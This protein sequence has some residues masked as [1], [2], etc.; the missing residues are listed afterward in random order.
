[1]VEMGSREIAV[2]CSYFRFNAFDILDFVT[3]AGNH[4]ELVPA[5]YENEVCVVVSKWGGSEVAILEAVLL[6]AFQLSTFSQNIILSSSLVTSES[7]DDLE[8][9]W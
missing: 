4:D 1:V 8:Q 2:T 7:S 6:Q 9:S 5:E 3:C